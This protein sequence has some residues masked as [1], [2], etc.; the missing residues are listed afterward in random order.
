MNHVVI[1]LVFPAQG[2]HSVVKS[3]DE[4]SI[5]VDS[6]RGLKE[7]QYDQV[8][9]PEASQEKVF[10]DT[11]VGLQLLAHVVTELLTIRGWNRMANILWVKILKYLFLWKS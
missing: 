4:Y 11:N 2:N 6:N 7:F 3:P 8:F 9:M 1:R 10:E 5:N